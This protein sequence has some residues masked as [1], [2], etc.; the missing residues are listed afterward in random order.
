[1]D[2]RVADEHPFLVARLAISAGRQNPLQPGGGDLERSQV[3]RDWIQHKHLPR[4]DRAWQVDLLLL[5][6]PV[7]PGKNI[8]VFH[9]REPA[10]ASP[11]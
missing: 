5:D 2:Y 7:R 9:E 10:P 1:M 3:A 8:T 4:R 11:A 6:R